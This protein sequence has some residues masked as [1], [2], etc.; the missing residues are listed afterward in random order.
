MDEDYIEISCD[1]AEHLI[2]FIKNHEPEDIPDDVWN[3]CMR[4]MEMLDIC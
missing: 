4:I 1:E 2:C 3:V